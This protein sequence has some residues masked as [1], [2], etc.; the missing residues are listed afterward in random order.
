MS[1]ATEIF[2]WWGGF[3]LLCGVVLVGA[4]F[5]DWFQGELEDDE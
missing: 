4:A 1:H 3:L 5:L 2:L